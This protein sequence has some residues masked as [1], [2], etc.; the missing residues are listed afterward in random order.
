VFRFE[1]QANFT[2]V[3]GADAIT[4]TTTCRRLTPRAAGDDAFRVRR[5][6]HTVGVPAA[7][8]YSFFSAFHAMGCVSRSPADC[9]ILAESGQRPKRSRVSQV[10][11]LRQ[12]AAR[13]RQLPRRGD[14]AGGGLVATCGG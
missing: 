5:P 11:A 9:Q 12:V 3:P 13:G 8:Q 1:I 2:L 4:E 10:H 14:P 6:F 7:Q